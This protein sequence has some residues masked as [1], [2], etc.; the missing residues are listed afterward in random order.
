MHRVEFQL[1][2]REQK[3]GHCT[4]AVIEDPRSKAGQMLAGIF[5]LHRQRMQ[6]SIDPFGFVLKI[7]KVGQH[8]SELV[9]LSGPIVA[10]DLEKNTERVFVIGEE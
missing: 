9:T 8:D 10:A 3:E 4:Q 6:V 2:T 7:G 5:V 1:K